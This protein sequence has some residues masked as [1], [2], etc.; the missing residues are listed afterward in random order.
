[1]GIIWLAVNQLLYARFGIVTNFESAKYIEQAD[2]LLSQGAYASGNFIF[3]S[4]PILIIALSK[5]TG[6]FPWLVVLLQLLVNAVSVLCF[7]RLNLRL[8]R[9]QL[10]SLVVTIL[11]VTMIYYQLYNFYLFTESLY[12]SFSILYTYLLFRIRKPSASNLLLLFGCLSLL[13]FTRPTGVFFVPATIL[14][15]VFRF[16]RRKAWTI[17]VLFGLAAVVLL[18]LLLNL[19]LPSGGEF[20]FLLPYLD[21][22][23]ICGVPTVQQK[24]AISIPGEKNSVEGLWYI[25]T[26][27]TGLFLDLGLRRLAAFFGVIRSHYSTWHNLYL[28]LYFWPV[29]AVIILRLRKL[30][31]YFLPESIFL[32]L[33][34]FFIM[35]TVVLS[36]DEWHNRFILA[37]LPF[38]LLL[39]STALLAKRKTGDLNVQ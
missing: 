31:R 34:I 25:I 13:Y 32:F 3:Y 37:L 29:Y 28:V 4:V 38:F 7:Y 9:N 30:I 21:E 26:H 19:A 35:V 15:L 36:C 17:T 33:N 2:F 39:G 10:G 16:Y 12:F 20:D 6:S 1:M 5:I 24:N 22:R 27:H 14:F 11:L 23:V 8:T 18:Y